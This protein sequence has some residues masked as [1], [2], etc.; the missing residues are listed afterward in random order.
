MTR[1]KT[2]S[3]QMQHTQGSIQ[4]RVLGA[5]L[6][7]SDTEGRSTTRSKSKKSTEAAP[8][9]AD[10]AVH[11]AHKSTADMP[12]CDGSQS[13]QCDT[14][15]S[16]KSP[17][18]ISPEEMESRA[19]LCLQVILEYEAEMSSIL[20]LA[21]ASSVG[22][23]ER[24]PEG[25]EGATETTSRAGGGPQ[26]KR[27]RHNSSEGSDLLLAE[28]GLQRFA[29]YEDF[30][31]A[32]AQQ[33]CALSDAPGDGAATQDAA[34][35][36]EAAQRRRE[37][38]MRY[39]GVRAHEEAATA[40]FPV[41]LPSQQD[42]SLYTKRS[43]ALLLLAG[44]SPVR[45]ED[46]RRSWMAPPQR[47]R[48]RHFAMRILM[49]LCSCSS[50]LP[51]KGS[52][53]RNPFE[54]LWP[55]AALLSFT[56][57]VADP[58]GESFTQSVLVWLSCMYAL[59]TALSPF[60]VPCMTVSTGTKFVALSQALRFSPHLQLIRSRREENLRGFLLF[61]SVQFLSAQ[62]ELPLE[63]LKANLRV[64][65]NIRVPLE[66]SRN[67][68]NQCSIR[69]RTWLCTCCFLEASLLK[70]PHLREASHK[71]DPLGALLSE[72]E[73]LRYISVERRHSG[74]G[75]EAEDTLFVAPTHRLTY[76]LHLDKFR[77]ECK[78]AV[79]VEPPDTSLKLP[80]AEELPG[81][82]EP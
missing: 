81:A 79:G 25:L 52:H 47:L 63:V 54:L 14:P 16:S 7:V 3:S 73:F 44:P 49:L 27:R 4:G 76:E 33:T 18:S 26:Q 71:I 42:S 10:G 20:P 68:L 58:P 19:E 75:E 28:K 38:D 70:A 39:L 57:C 78:A 21:E 29:A 61:L 2:R 80:E 35:A 82:P 66:C 41:C 65:G 64:T 67:P 8:D 50:S 22:E 5:D 59:M 6:G 72:C 23:F 62:A 34:L 9:E 32:F 53:G 74:V 51:M 46:M 11:D 13:Q 37:H 36:E 43:I 24:D 31:P 30:K 48:R 40:P 15:G 45:M 60:G 77:S 1:E 55:S 56:R 12:P 17:V 69:V